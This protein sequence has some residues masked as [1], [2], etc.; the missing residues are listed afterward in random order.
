MSVYVTPIPHIPLL[1]VRL[2][3]WLGVNE[4]C[5]QTETRS[6]QKLSV[7]NKQVITMRKAHQW[8]TQSFVDLRSQTSWQAT[9]GWCDHLLV[10][11][12][13]TYFVAVSSEWSCG[14]YDGWVGWQDKLLTNHTSL[15]YTRDLSLKMEG[16]GVT[17]HTFQN[18]TS[19]DTSFLRIQA[20]RDY[21][22]LY[23]TNV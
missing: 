9:S 21:T 17:Q 14:M 8:K 20:V 23:Y 4:L 13:W 3:K 22:S 5:Y 15:Y 6:V 16:W 2:T 11:G 12:R 1:Q 19:I 18:Y 7:W 10:V